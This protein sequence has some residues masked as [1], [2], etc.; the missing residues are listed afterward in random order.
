MNELKPITTEK[1]YTSYLTIMGEYAKETPVKLN[2]EELL[3]VKHLAI[4]L[5]AYEA[6]SNPTQLAET[7]PISIIRLRMH[8]RQLEPKDMVQYLGSRSKVSEVLNGKRP[9]TLS[10]IRR[11]SVGLQIP[12][13]L[14]INESKELEEP[15]E[16][17]NWK[18]FP[19]AEMM[20]R[21]WFENLTVDGDSGRDEHLRDFFDFENADSLLAIYR[22]GITVRHGDL[23]KEY[24][25]TAWV[26]RV[27]TIVRGSTLGSTSSFQ[28]MLSQAYLENIASYSCRPSGH[29]TAINELREIGIAVVYEPQLKGANLDGV[30]TAVDGI[31]V[32]GL[33]LRHDRIDH[34]WFTLLH[35]LVHV[36]KHIG[37][38]E[39]CVLLDDFEAEDSEAKVEAEA[40]R[41]AR[42]ALIPR[43]HW[44]KSEVS[45]SPSV[46]SILDLSKKIE[47]DPS[48]VAGRVRYE[49]K[50]YSQFSDLVGTGNFKSSLKRGVQ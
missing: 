31:P 12:A 3:Y 30:A 35:E 49:T 16:L 8:E 20:K 6:E 13:D 32:I 17:K 29:L 9:L 5:Q 28:S 45:R 15:T 33:T 2:K 10:M 47:R 39:N 43:S 36:W 25:R 1:Q 38:H 19:Y 23:N 48:I 41:I 34:F 18:L 22:K 24:A 14:L 26:Q 11:L 21:G 46:R 27:R 42:D 40:N 4:L 37:V 7:D 50:N 44:R